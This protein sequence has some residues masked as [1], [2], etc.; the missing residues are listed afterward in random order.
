MN[1]GD[2]FKVS[3]LHL[4]CRRGNLEA[5]EILL[6]HPDIIVD[7]K[8]EHDDTP[9]HEACLHGSDTVVEKLL[10]NNVAISHSF[11]DS[12]NEDNQTPLH[13]ACREGHTK[14]VKML[15]EQCPVGHLMTFLGAHDSRGNTAFHLAVESFGVSETLQLVVYFQACNWHDI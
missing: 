12:F 7:I 13:L 9:L 14:I 4:A 11:Y 1:V 2:K 8:D 3:A 10:L 15:L 6:S 5:A